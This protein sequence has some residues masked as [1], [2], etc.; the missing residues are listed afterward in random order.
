MLAGLT[1]DLTKNEKTMA[2]C[3]SKN[4]PKPLG[5]EGVK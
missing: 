1:V 4:V 3:E 5:E 2:I